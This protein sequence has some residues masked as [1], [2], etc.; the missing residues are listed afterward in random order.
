[1]NKQLFEDIIDSI[2][3]HSE[4]WVLD[5]ERLQHKIYGIKLSRDGN[6]DRYCDV[7]PKTTYYQR[8]MI[9][10]LVSRT[11]RKMTSEEEPVRIADF[12]KW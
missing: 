9:G 12:E 6:V 11:I 2:T 3:N 7:N 8:F 5:R 4:E 1:M 10:R